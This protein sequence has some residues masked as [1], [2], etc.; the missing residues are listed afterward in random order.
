MIAQFCF[1]NKLSNMAGSVS[2]HGV[3]AL[4]FAW[5][6]SQCKALAVEELIVLRSLRCLI[7][8]ERHL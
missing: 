5:V 1:L 8:L 4:S 6:C 3:I 2:L 7:T